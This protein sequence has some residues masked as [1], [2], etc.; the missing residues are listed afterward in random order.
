MTTLPPELEFIGDKKPY[1]LYDNE[2]NTKTKSTKTG[3]NGAR[4][5]FTEIRKTIPKDFLD[6]FHFNNIINLMDRYYYKS[7]SWRKYRPYIGYIEYTNGEKYNEPTFYFHLSKS[8][9]NCFRPYIMNPSVINGPVCFGSPRIHEDASDRHFVA[10][11][12]RGAVEDQIMYFKYY[13]NNAQSGIHQ[14]HH[15]DITFINIMLGFANQVMKI[16]SRVDFESY[17]RPFG[18]YYGSRGSC[19]D[20]DNIKGMAISDA[21]AKYHKKHAKLTLIEIKE[22]RGETSEEIKFNT[23]LR[24]KIKEVE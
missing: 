21:F 14:V 10:K 9:N 13:E 20:V 12:F 24:N 16:D 17:I 22:H 11:M 4:D 19:F 23:S 1:K 3:Q 8:F 5:A 18:K 2:Y 15:E 7:E 6:D